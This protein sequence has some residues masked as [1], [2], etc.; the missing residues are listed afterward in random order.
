MKNAGSTFQCNVVLQS[1]L[2][3]KVLKIWKAA[4]YIRPLLLTRIRT[5]SLDWRTTQAV[6]PTTLIY[7]GMLEHSWS[8]ILMYCCSLILGTRFYFLLKYNEARI[9]GY[10]LGILWISHTN[11]V[12]SSCHTNQNLNVRLYSSGILNPPS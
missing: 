6:F 8:N 3:D 11:W 7:V 4:G 9:S 1:S 10:N 2:G 12:N 5:L